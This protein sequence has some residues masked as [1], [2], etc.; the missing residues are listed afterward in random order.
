MANTINTEATRQMSVVT[1]ASAEANCPFRFSSTSCQTSIPVIQAF[2]PPSILAETYVEE[3]IK[4]TMVA[5]SRNPGSESGSSMVKNRV[6]RDAP[7]FCAASMMRGGVACKTSYKDKIMNG[8][9]ACTNPTLI[10]PYVYSMCELDGNP[11]A[12]R[13]EFTKPS[14]ASNNSTPRERTTTFT[15]SGTSTMDMARGRRRGGNDTIQSA[16]G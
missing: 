4:N 8:R 2:L 11:I 7:R 10:A 3:A 6:A 5:P 16:I 9:N 12:F 14:G 15:S 13:Q 1:T